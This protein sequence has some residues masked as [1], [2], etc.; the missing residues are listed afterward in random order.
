M[1]PLTVAAGLLTVGAITPGPNNLIVMRESAHR[2]WRGAL[3]AGIGI[4]SGGLAL[5]MTVAAGLN[6]LFSMASGWLRAMSI[7]SS[8]LLVVLG[9]AVIEKSFRATSSPPPAT[10]ARSLGSL[11]ALF[12]FQFLNPKAWIMVVAIVSSIGPSAELAQALPQ[13]TALFI[14]IPAVCLML[15]SLIGRLAMRAIEK[16]Q[17]RAYFDRLMG[18]LLIGFAFLLLIGGLDAV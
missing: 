4:V 6:T 2:G 9:V 17:V 11:G 10:P 16:P 12:L 7:G 14:L 13:L 5:L 1:E 18:A 3:S 15:W 8:L